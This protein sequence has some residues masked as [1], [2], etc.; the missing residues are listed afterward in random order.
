M[1]IGLTGILHRFKMVLLLNFLQAVVAEI[2]FCQTDLT[3][4]K[5]RLCQQNLSDRQAYQRPQ[6][7]QRRCLPR[8]M[9]PEGLFK[10]QDLS[11]LDFIHFEECVSFVE[12]NRVRRPKFTL[13]PQNSMFTIPAS[14][15]AILYCFS[16]LFSTRIWHHAQVLI[17]GAILCPGTR[18]ISAVLRVLGLSQARSFS[19]YHRVPQP[20]RLLKPQGCPSSV[21]SSGRHIPSF[22]CSGAGH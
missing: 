13:T 7:Y 6:K 4:K 3:S 5:A 19:K 18:T 8:Q 10:D 16:D 1:L 21:H 22:R 20:R 9:H 12:K 17:L 14:I 11:Q 2:T 15:A